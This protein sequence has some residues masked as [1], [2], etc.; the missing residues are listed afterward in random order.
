MD[1]KEM[2]HNPEDNQ[3]TSLPDEVRVVRNLRML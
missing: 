3:R 1:N 2:T